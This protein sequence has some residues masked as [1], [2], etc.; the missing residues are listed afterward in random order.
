MT[1]PTETVKAGTLDPTFADAGVLKIHFPEI[2]GDAAMAVLATSDKK[3]MVA[4]PLWG[5]ACSFCDS[6]TQ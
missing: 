5:G 1:Q 3:L 2:S 4:I 6:A